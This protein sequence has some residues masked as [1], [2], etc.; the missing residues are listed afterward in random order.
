MHIRR[1]FD[2]NADFL[3]SRAPSAE[4]LHTKYELAFTRQTA[5]SKTL[6]SYAWQSAD[7]KIRRVRILE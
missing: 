4:G 1:V 3:R 5:L 7:V 6:H 2:S